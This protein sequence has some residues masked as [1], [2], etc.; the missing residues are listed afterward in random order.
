MRKTFILSLLL[1]L[2]VGYSEGRQHT[3]VEGIRYA[4][5]KSHTRV[6]IDLDGP[7]EFSENHLKNPP[8]I[9]FD[10]TNC[11][12]SKKNKSHIRIGSTVLDSVRMAQFNSKTVRVVFDI[13]NVKNYY[14]FTLDNPFRLVVDFYPKGTPLPL[15]R[16]GRH[17]KDILVDRKI[18]RAKTVVIDAGHGG[19]DPGAIGPRG[20][21][22]KDVTLHVAKRLGHILKKKYG[23]NV[24]YTRDRDVFVPLNERTEIA[25]SSGAD[26]FVSIHVNASR[27]RKTRGI[28]TYFLNWT[29]NREALRV[30]AREN[31]V[32]IRKMQQMRD[33]LQM[34]LQDLARKNKNDESMR[35]A[36]SVQS[37][38]V[39][40]LKRRYSKIENLG[41]KYALFYV[42]VGAEMPSVLVEVSFISNYEEERRLAS[43]L[44]RE[45]IAE[46][47]AMGIN[48]YINESSLVVGP[49]V[50]V[51]T[52]RGG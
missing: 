2:L 39:N 45:K 47:I 10:L 20:V 24:I 21:K 3:S 25:N 44:Y 8:R 28:E 22:E 16:S 23:L 13:G 38:M 6:V 18:S 11:R 7:V 51:S 5:Y 46:A 1:C 50:S 17:E 29:N 40:N 32:S 43:R 42:L 48:S 52:E 9:Y 33:S 31:R 19:K 27:N 49:A 41:V 15:R 37:S 12:I 30:A 35:L 36:Y 34:I 4:S 14:A 26:L